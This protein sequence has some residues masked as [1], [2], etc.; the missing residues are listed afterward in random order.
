[1]LSGDA[2]EARVAADHLRRV[3]RA[4][5]T[6]RLKHVNTF[7]GNDH[8]F[9]VEHNFQRFLEVW[10]GLVRDAEEQGIFV[11]IENCP[12]LFTRDEWP[13]GKNLAY[14]PAI[15]R[16]IFEA[17]GS[18]HF[19]L[20]YDPSHMVWQMMDWELPIFEFRDRLFHVHAKDMKIEREL[21]DDGGILSL[22][23]S[24]PKIPGLGDVNWPRFISALTDVEYDGAVCV[25]VEDEA[26]QPDLED[27][28]RA[29]K[30][31]RNVLRPLVG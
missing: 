14:S 25:E 11:G 5:R 21:L 22:G 12:M 27:R 20:N 1:M 3:F 26:F 17:I 28:Q 8:R 2:E 29:L 13:S 30:I 23:W 31:A 10:P 4:A 19:G 6:L 15:W 16:E 18:D 9:H 24:T 7:I